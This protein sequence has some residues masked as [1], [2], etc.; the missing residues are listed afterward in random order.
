MTHDRCVHG[1]LDEVDERGVCSTEDDYRTVTSVCRH[2]SISCRRATF[3]KIE[4]LER[5]I[6]VSM[7]VNDGIYLFKIICIVILSI[8]TVGVG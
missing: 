6:Q 1:E 7:N 3:I 5:G 4:V 8:F 2:I